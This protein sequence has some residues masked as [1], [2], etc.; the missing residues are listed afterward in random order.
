[1]GVVVK[2][3]LETDEPKTFRMDDQ[4]PVISI[5]FS[6]DQKILAIQRCTTS[7]EFM[8]FNGATIETPYSQACK[9]NANI[10]GFVW[11][12]LNEVA[13]IT[14]H[15]IEL[16]T[17]IPEKKTIKHLKSISTTVQWFLWCSTNNMALL[18]S[19]H[20]SHLLPMII[21]ASSITKLPKLESKFMIIFLESLE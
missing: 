18:A 15:G 17:V 7:V 11:S 8:N 20:G 19:Q 13:F 21:K 14:D 1:M 2:G 10:I 12:Q 4:G 9:K 16:Y 6:L 5:K 3:P